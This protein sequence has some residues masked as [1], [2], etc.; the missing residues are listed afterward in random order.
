MMKKILS[1]FLLCILC[2]YANSIGKPAE[3]TYEWLTQGEGDDGGSDHV[4]CLKEVFNKIKVRSTL[5]F[6]L[7]Y[8]TKYL[9]DSCARV[10]SVEVVTH[11]YGPA[12]IQ[13]FLQFYRD[14]SNW[15]PITYF[16]GYQGDMS[17]A[18]YKYLGSDSVYKAC[19][20]QNA[21]HQSYEPIDPFYLKEL[22][23]FVTNLTK[24]NKID[25]ALV[26]P[27]LF[28]RGDLV[29][30]LFD[31]VG[32]I[33]AHNTS[34]RAKKGKDEGWGYTRVAT[35]NNYEE[36]YIATPEGTTVWVAKKDEY[37]PL[38]QSLKQL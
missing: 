20:Y 4:V 2:L 36:I 34:T 30:L 5:E 33:V 37:Q 23:E 12:K 15:I 31:K 13:K 6:G 21:T 35:P 14:Y 16:S 24:Y 29:Q 1:C 17:W 22:G 32:V 25:V 11:G 10:L 38:I 19:S 8:S 28:L 7:G 27:I 9:L 18:P 26:H 3:I